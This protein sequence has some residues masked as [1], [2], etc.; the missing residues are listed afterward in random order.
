ME[1]SKFLMIVIIFLLILNI[2]TLVFFFFNPG[3]R[4]SGHHRGKGGPASFIIQELG[5]DEK[6]QAAFNDLKKEHQSQMKTMMDSMNLQRELLPDLIVNGN[7]SKA[8][9]VSTAI[10]KHQK[11]I[12]VYTYEHF[13]KVYALCNGDQKEKFKNIIGDILHMMA[14]PKG[15][16]PPR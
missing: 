1:K 2:G 10:G 3:G 13:V 4:P 6:Q 16:P 15:G 9:S 7:R 5:F 8:D 14:P 12:E 11:Q